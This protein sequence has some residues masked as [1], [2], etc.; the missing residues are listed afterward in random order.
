MRGQIRKER[1]R[2][3]GR[4]LQLFE[5]G[6]HVLLV[7]GGSVGHAGGRTPDH[8]HETTAPVFGGLDDGR[9][10]LAV[11][12]E[13]VAPQGDLQSEGAA[14]PRHFLGSVGGEDRR[15]R[16]PTPLAVAVPGLESGPFGSAGGAPNPLSALVLGAP[17]AHAAE[18]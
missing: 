12:L 14:L 1:L 11:W 3:L 17:L 10:A 7:L 5:G 9:A 15:D 2:G 13:P 16:R 18:V 4:L 8:V 6:A